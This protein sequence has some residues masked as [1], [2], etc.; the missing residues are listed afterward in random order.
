MLC[1]CL[2]VYNA[3]PPNTFFSLDEGLSAWALGLGLSPKESPEGRYLLSLASQYQPEQYQD[4]YSLMSKYQT[5]CPHF[6]KPLGV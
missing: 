5:T 3:A 6:L 2:Y 4:S 1:F